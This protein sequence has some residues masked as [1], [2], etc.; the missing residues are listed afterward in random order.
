MNTVQESTTN[1]L[2]VVAGVAVAAAT[3]TAC[4]G[5]GGDGGGNDAGGPPGGP[6]PVVLPTAVSITGVKIVDDAAAP[7]GANGQPAAAGGVAFNLDGGTAG[8]SLP[9]DPGADGA[10]RTYNFTPTVGG[11]F[12]V[13]INPTPSNVY[14]SLPLVLNTARNAVAAASFPPAWDELMAN[15]GLT[16]SQI[17]QRLVGRMRATPYEAYPAWID[18]RILSWTQFSALS[19][20]AKTAYNDR[21][22]PRR[23]E[24]KA[25]WLRQMVRS[26]DPLGE[27]LLMF[28]H[29]VFT[30]SFNS[31]EEPETMVRQHRTWRANQ[32]GNLR[33]FL[34][35]LTRDPG[36]CIYLDSRTNRK[37]SPNTNF[38]RELME[39]FTL[40]E[41]TQFGA[42]AEADIP[43]VA[44]CF[45]GYHL[46]DNHEFTFVPDQ[47]DFSTK[48]L[49]GVTWADDGS[50]LAGDWVIDQILAKVDISGHRSCA[51]YIVTRLWREF[52]G[53]V[54]STD[55]RVLALA[56]KFS[57]DYAYELKPLYQAL[58]THAAFTD[59]AVRGTRMRSP[60]ELLV[61]F[62][63]PLGIEP[64][65]YEDQTWKLS[66][67]DQ[68][69][70]D[71]PNVFGWPGGLAWINVKNAVN[72]Q[73]YMEWTVWNDRAKLP[74]RLFPVLGL[75][76]MAI[77]PVVAPTGTTT[78]NKVFAY[79]KD[80]A[81]NLR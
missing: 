5:G 8:T 27:R 56:N 66:S 35:A 36:M 43:L 22:W 39:L 34:K 48:T 32:G 51:V 19:E 6:P 9:K 72:R 60:V 70:L 74:E 1:D 31:L 18:E 30:S 11:A 29:G 16:Q 23:T 13:T 64:D 63:R 44:K 57:N 46:N 81:F 41:R 12:T 71:P 53:P 26:P 58:L 37:G 59:P 73:T 2:L 42:Y 45:T 76:L 65:V 4:G 68:D 15:A 14:S 62:W 21:R 79:V 25:W 54:L 55:A 33:T 20:A 10:A 49:W 67:L 38:A 24:M 80:P 28:W 7:V 3:L 17:I 75:L 69:L 47:H 77:D 50:Q 40:G 61:G 78:Q 52:I